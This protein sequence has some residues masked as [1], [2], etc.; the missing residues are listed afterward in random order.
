MGY[1][2]DA[3]AAFRR[4]ET[5]LVE[6]L[7]RRELARARAS[8]DVATEVEA[9]C[10]LARVAVR[11]GDVPEAERLGRVARALARSTG[12]RR[13]ER[14]PTH[15]LAGCARISG[16]LAFARTLYQESISLNETFGEWRMV[17][18]ELHN[19]A[20]IELHAGDVDR[21]RELFTTAR[22]RTVAQD[23]DDMLPY[24]ALDTAVMAAVDGDHQRATR[25]LAALDNTLRA[26]GQILDPD[27]SIEQTTLRE[28]L[29]TTLGR[30]SFEALYATGASLGL[31]DALDV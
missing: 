21:A 7:S 19:L 1:H 20:Y 24:V 28:E 31:R 29:V 23:I 6:Q 2:D 25:L 30:K 15:I 16:N 13:L 9:L 18:V 11:D 5:D 3:F 8:S 14:A 4:G 22:M 10:M 26:A 12:E 17:V 27:D